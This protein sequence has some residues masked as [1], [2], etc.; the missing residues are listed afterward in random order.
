[1]SFNIANARGNND[2]FFDTQ[3]KEKIEWGLNWLS[4]VIHYHNIDVICLN[5]A[6]SN[7]IRTHGIDTAKYIATKVCYNHI[8][9]EKLF[10][11]PAILEVGMSSSAGIL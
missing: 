5:E 9:N 8:I 4:A 3:P 2:N 11:L 10:S 6:D 1:M 7:S